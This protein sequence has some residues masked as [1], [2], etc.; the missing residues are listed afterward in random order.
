VLALI[1]AIVGEF[2]GASVG[3]GSLI[4][5]RQAQVDVSGVFSILAYLSVMGLLL[6]LSVKLIGRRI[7]F[8]NN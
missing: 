6:T 3:L 4:I 2:V 8:W 5:Q 1:G 7:V